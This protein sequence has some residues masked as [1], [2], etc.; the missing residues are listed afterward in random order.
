MAELAS[1]NIGQELFSD[2]DR[3]FNGEAA[4]INTSVV[5]SVFEF[6]KTL[7]A[8]ELVG[9]VGDELTI[10]A[11]YAMTITVAWDEDPAGT[12]SD[13]QVVASIAPSTV[14]AG[15]EL[16]RYVADHVKPVWYKVTIASTD[17]A[18]VGTINVDIGSVRK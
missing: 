16:F 10:A 3:I 15:A 11:T 12:F 4:P 7:D 18:S 2:T 8:L 1:S 17:L 14:G 9:T 13:T 5:S 6:G